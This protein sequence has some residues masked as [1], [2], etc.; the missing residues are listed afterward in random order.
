MYKKLICLVSLVLLFGLVG[1]VSAGT[2]TW[3]CG[4]GT[5]ELWSTGANWDPD[6]EP[7]SADGV[8]IWGTLAYGPTINHSTAQASY[9]WTGNAAGTVAFTITSTGSL[10]T[11]N[12]NM[13]TA[14]GAEIVLNMNGGSMT[15]GTGGSNWAIGYQG[16]GGL[17]GKGI[18]NM[19]SGTI[20]CESQMIVS[21]CDNWTDNYSWGRVYLHGGS[22]TTATLAIGPEGGPVDHAKVE[23]DGDGTLIINGDVTAAI[24][25]YITAGRIYGKDGQTVLYDYDNINTGK[26]TV[27]TPEPATIALLALGGLFLRKRR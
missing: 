17:Y 10:T 19:N 21:N 26:T 16:G 22:I 2:K 27:W 7:T 1:N 4:G 18:V 6:G 15:V 25:A 9:M 23:F 24:A 14:G 13:A 8:H 12:W 11:G 5:D 3:D 20:T